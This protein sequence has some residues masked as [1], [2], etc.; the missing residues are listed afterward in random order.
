M[1]CRRPAATATPCAGF[2][3]TVHSHA[4]GIE[5]MSRAALEGIGCGIGAGSLAARYHMNR[6]RAMK[7]A[8][9][10]S[11][12]VQHCTVNGKE[13]M[14]VWAGA[15]G[16]GRCSPPQSINN[17]RRDKMKTLY[18]VPPRPAKSGRESNRG[19][20]LV[21]HQRAA[22]ALAGLAGWL[23]CRRTAASSC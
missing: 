7:K 8:G 18:G 17:K 1:A 4:W 6:P 10:E 13:C 5:Q 16:C 23:I 11:N 3:F 19:D 14:S 15:R 22:L 2:G 9:R 12:L 20:Q 21:F